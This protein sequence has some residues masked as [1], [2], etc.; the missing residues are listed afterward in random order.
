ML[1]LLTLG[2]LDIRPPDAPAAAG[3][4]KQ[5]KRVA[6][7]AFLAVRGAGGFV[8]RNALLG[9]FWPDAD[10]QRARATLRTTLH[11]LRSQLPDG[12][13]E[14]RGDDELRAAPGIVW[15]DAVAFRQAVDDGRLDEALALYRGPL[16]A[17]FLPAGIPDFNDWVERERQA[18]AQVAATAA[19]TLYQR[20]CAAGS[21]DE[22]VAA[23]RRWVELAPFEEPAIRALAAA[24]ADAGD[25][26]GALDA[27]DAW[28]THLAAELDTVPGPET[29]NLERHLRAASAPAA[30]HAPR[31][32]TSAPRTWNVMRAT[33]PRALAA[34][35][36]LV[37]AGASVTGL[38]AR[39]RVT[40]RAAVPASPMS[41]AVL[42]FSYGGNQDYAY[43]RHGLVDLLAAR[44]NTL[45][46]VPVT[47]PRAVLAQYERVSD[48]ES[49]SPAAGREVGVRLGASFFVLGSVV[50]LNGRIS[51]SAALYD[52]TQ[53]AEVAQVALVGE[54]AELF[55]MVDEVAYALARSHIPAA[56][57]Q[58]PPDAEGYSTRS[59]EALRHFVDGE[60][61]FTRGHF[62]AA[63]TAY[64]RATLLDST[65]ARAHLRLSMAGTWAND[66]Q[67]TRVGLEQA[68]RFAQR[69][70]ADERVL[71]QAW[72]AHLR[73]PRPLLADS[74]YRAYLARHPEDADAWL[75]LGEVRFHWGPTIGIPPRAADEAFA[76]ALRLRPGHVG[77]LIHRIRLA[78]R[79]HGAG[80]TE[81]LYQAIVRQQPDARDVFE[82]DLVAAL[83]AEDTIRLHQA[84]EAVHAFDDPA[85]LAI[86]HVAAATAA[87]L[88]L[89]RRTVSAVIRPGA[90]TAEYQVRD[91]ELLLAAGRLRAADSAIALLKPDLA[92]ERGA[93]RAVLP[94]LEREPGRIARARAALAAAPLAPLG[95]SDYYDV[96][97]TL[98]GVSQTR[99]L[100]LLALLDVRAGDAASAAARADSL[101]RFGT[102]MDLSYGRRFATLVRAQLRM[103]AGDP[104]GALDLLGTPAVEPF[105]TYPR[106]SSWYLA[107]ERWLRAD[108]LARSGNAAEA[109]AWL[110]TFPDF[111]AYDIAWAPH[112]LL[113]LSELYRAAG[114]D[115]DARWARQ[116]AARMWRDADPQLRTALDAACSSSPG[117]APHF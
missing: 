91:I 116:R 95:V 41:V 68:T 64:R 84:F 75:Q 103:D 23:A 49:L 60:V 98:N 31:A 65:F 66:W 100:L 77:G 36:A 102:G 90:R 58:V 105:G 96:P 45:T 53:G 93:L 85:R 107:F 92:A 25:R 106:V 109:I 76:R 15:C 38:V 2:G 82:A 8:S 97:E 6:V 24:L 67:T 83:T 4:L 110:E 112:A 72:D 42:P 111:S 11:Y 40:V 69:L 108:A 47:D 13:I 37:L 104:R 61:E 115:N 10:E 51:L 22:A 63:I 16:L 78:A 50:E 73:D 9:V 71:L 89:G 12:A 117:C 101:A 56:A 17:G 28:K 18:L 26:T 52:A 113:R 30:E 55:E 43:L 114:R 48:G 62:G 99:R 86:G 32:E 5:P 14:T 19:R 79:L 81:A 20:A 7:L 70:A 29:R 74:L 94:F 3:L 1:R 59:A 88:A 34:V 46:D 33:R 87:D 80:A 27:L 39:S 35:V 21:D 54:V 57:A 44:L